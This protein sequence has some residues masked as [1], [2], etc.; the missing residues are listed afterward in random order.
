VYTLTNAIELK[1]S[2]W[3]GV[4]LLAMALL[5]FFAIALAALPLSVKWALA[6]GVAVATGFALVRQRQPL[7]SLR[8][9][10]DGGLWGWSDTGDW[11]QASVLRGSFASAALCVLDLDL[12]GR[13]WVMTLLPDSTDADAW[14]RLRVSL[15]WQG[16][17]RSDIAARDAG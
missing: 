4:L 17:R 11:A 8:I 10:P 5:G 1:P 12:G 9:D 6:A 14:R 15:R 13:R 7:P 2:R 16:H 3:L